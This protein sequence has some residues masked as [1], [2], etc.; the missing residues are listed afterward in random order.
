MKYFVLAM[1]AAVLF[2]C[3][4]GN[5]PAGILP[6]S[7]MEMVLWD[8]VNADAYAYSF[9]SKDSGKDVPLENVRLQLAIFKKY[10]ISKKEFYDSYTYYQRNPKKLRSMLDSI[11]AKA[12]RRDTMSFP[13][14]VS[15]E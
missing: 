11:E 12:H 10:Q 5:V 14:K 15:Y 8:Y 2:S 1:F 6:P 9:I 4:E 13:K 3:K 7:K